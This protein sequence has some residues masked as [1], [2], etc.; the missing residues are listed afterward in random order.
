MDK[1]ADL[2]DTLEGARRRFTHWHE[3]GQLPR[4]ERLIFKNR[5]ATQTS[6]TSLLGKL[7]TER[8]RSRVEKGGLGTHLGTFSTGTCKPA[9]A[10]RRPSTQPPSPAS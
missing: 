1:Q 7:A 3:W 9:S 8:L 2:G 5:F 4:L 10:T 6:G